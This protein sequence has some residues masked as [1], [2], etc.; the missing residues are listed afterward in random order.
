[1]RAIVYALLVL[2]GLALVLVLFY[3][4]WQQLAERDR[5]L[6]AMKAVS[7]PE[8]LT[9]EERAKLK[10]GRSSWWAVWLWVPDL[11]WRLPL[12]R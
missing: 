5:F 9:A 1:M 7:H 4:R 10:L 6:L 12:N 8:N 11:W 3:R 2:A